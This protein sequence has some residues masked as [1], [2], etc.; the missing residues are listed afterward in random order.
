MKNK[1]KRN[2]CIFVLGIFMLIAS[3]AINTSFAAA[4]KFDGYIWS[5]DGWVVKRWN[6]DKENTLKQNII[7]LFYPNSWTG[8]NRI[9]NVIRDMTLWIMIIFIVWAWASLLLNKDSKNVGKAMSS[10]LYIVLWGVFIFWAN[11]LFW[12]VLNFNQTDVTPSLQWGGIWWVKEALIWNDSVLFRVL[13]VVKVAAFFLAIIMIV[14]TWFRVISAWEWDKWK[15]LVKWLVNVVVALIVIKWVDFI[16]YMAADWNFVDRAA[17]FIVDA[18]KLFAYLYGVVIVIMVF[19]A[20]YLFITDGWSGSNFKKAGNLLIN[21]LLSALVL[22]GFLLI[23]YQ[24]FAEFRTWG[25]AVTFNVNYSV[26]S[27]SQMLNNLK[28]V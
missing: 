19:V 4:P 2:L 15:K 8:G 20:G 18:A 11:R 1:I 7:E 9:F 27:V 6:V 3:F 12:S 17:N 21:I 14:V 5:L 25:D 10:L 23:L 13:S 24:V 28:Y 22:F 16:Y 26:E